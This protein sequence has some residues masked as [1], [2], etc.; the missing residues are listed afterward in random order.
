MS[1]T[2][3]LTYLVAGIAIGSVVSMTGAVFS[4]YRYM[5]SGDLDKTGGPMGT[6]LVMNGAL[7]AIGVVAL[8]IGAIAG[9]L[10][11]A[12]ITGFGVFIGFGIVFGVM[13]Y[14]W[15]SIDDE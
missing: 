10:V 2:D 3:V 15:L 6:I 8:V 1:S 12:I 4:Y 7:V 9:E 11:A 13:L 5:N 14:L